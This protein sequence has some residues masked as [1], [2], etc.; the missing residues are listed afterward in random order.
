MAKNTYTNYWRSNGT[1]LSA[2]SFFI[3]FSFFLPETRI[4]CFIIIG[5]H[6]A[7]R[8]NENQKFLRELALSTGNISNAHALK[9]PLLKD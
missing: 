6:T 2:R 7:L 1:I 9:D 3:F 8:M 4:V 5:R